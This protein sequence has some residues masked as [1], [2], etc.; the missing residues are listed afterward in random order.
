[1]SSNA[2][3][4]WVVFSY[5]AQMYV[6]TRVE[7]QRIVGTKEPNQ[8]LMNA[9]VES[10]LLHM[11]VLVDIILSRGSEKDTI[12]LEHLIPQ[13]SESTDLASAVESLKR[14]YGSRSREDSPC[15]VVNK[16]LVHP[17]LWRRNSY[18]YTAIFG[19]LDPIIKIALHQIGALSSRADIQ[20]CAHDL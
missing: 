16:M 2:N 9:L 4:P 5:E 17:T 11:R 3:D 15:W 10:A 6:L 20:A 14:E 7:H 12:R 8:I 19:R 13:W 1:M 18:D